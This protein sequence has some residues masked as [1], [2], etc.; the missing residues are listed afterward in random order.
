MKRPKP[1][2]LK[3]RKPSLRKKRKKNSKTV[4]REPR[5]RRTSSRSRRSSWSR[6]L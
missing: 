3:K 2:N 6:S 1:K 5:A 4:M